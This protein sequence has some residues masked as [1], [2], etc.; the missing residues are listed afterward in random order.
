MKFTYVK[1]HFKVLW[2]GAT[3]TKD[4]IQ[5][6]PWPTGLHYVFDFTCFDAQEQSLMRG[7]YYIAPRLFITPIS[8]DLTIMH[9][10]I[11]P[12]IGLNSPQSHLILVDETIILGWKVNR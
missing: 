6:D 12:T 8:P 11:Y 9:L 4:M 10:H 2:Q 7:F 1:H 3:Q 5:V